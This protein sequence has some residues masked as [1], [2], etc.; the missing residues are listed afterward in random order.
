MK[1]LIK[2]ILPALI[3]LIIGSVQV[4][5]AHNPNGRA[6][7]EY[8]GTQVDVLFDEI[9]VTS[10]WRTITSGALCEQAGGYTYINWE[11]SSD[12]SGKM[13]FRVTGGSI[14]ESKLVPYK[15]NI[16]FQTGTIS[17]KRYSLSARRENII[18]P[19]TD[20]KGSWTV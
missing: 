6:A 7:S 11:E 14:S 20:I 9:G 19:P 12:S 5:A 2:C 17:G 1:K 3:L 8:D 18:D 4:S 15:G 16:K 13:W 10:S